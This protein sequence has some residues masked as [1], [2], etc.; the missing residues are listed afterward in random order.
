MFGWLRR[1]TA[2]RVS[3]GAVDAGGTIVFGLD[4]ESV[5]QVLQQG[6]ARTAKVFICYRRADS[7]A[8][9]GRIA[10][11]LATKFG[12]DKVFIDIDRIVAGVDFLSAISSEIQQCDVV[13][14]IMGRNLAWF[15][16]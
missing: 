13:F 8:T 3:A 2:D 6:L 10:D 16:G 9:A 1:I 14:A 5:R 11:A 4:E 12:T 7:S 15:V